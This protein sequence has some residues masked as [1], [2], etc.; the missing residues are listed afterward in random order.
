MM[1]GGVAATNRRLVQRPWMTC[2]AMNV[3]ATVALATST[4]PITSIAA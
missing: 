3:A 2:P 4:D 1:S